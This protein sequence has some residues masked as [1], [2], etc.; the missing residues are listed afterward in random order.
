MAT[1][2]STKTRQTTVKKEAPGTKSKRLRSKLGMLMSVADVHDA[3]AYPKTV[4]AVMQQMYLGIIP[5]A[6]ADRLITRLKQ[7]CLEC[8]GTPYEQAASLKQDPLLNLRPLFER[9]H[10][11][12]MSLAQSVQDL[13]D[14]R[15]RLDEKKKWLR[16]ITGILQMQKEARLDA[17][18]YWL[19]VGKDDNPSRAGQRVIYADCHVLMFAV[20]ND[21][22]HPHSLIEAPVGHGKS[23]NLRGQIS[24]EI[25]RWPELRHLYLTESKPL[26]V[27]TIRSLRKI[28]TS[29]R[30]KVLFPAVNILD[31]N[32]KAE[33]SSQSFTVGRLNDQARDPTIMG[34]GYKGS[35]QG[36]RY[37]RIW[38]DDVCP[39]DVKKQ[40]VVREDN[41]RV[42]THV[43]RTRLAD[44]KNSKIR[45]I[46][47]P[48]HEDDILG[49]T[50]RDWR[51]GIMPKWR[52]EIDRFRIKIDAT[53]MPIPIWPALWDAE[54]LLAEK[55]TNSAFRFTH[56]LRFDGASTR[57]LSNVYFYNSVPRTGVD[58]ESDFALN[59]RICQGERWLSIDPAGTGNAWSSGQGLVEFV[60][61]P[62]GYAFLTNVWFLQED[63][64]TFVNR[65][66]DII[67]D[68]SV[69]GN[70]RYR[71]TQ[72]EVQ[73]G[74]KI[75][76]PGLEYMFKQL[77]A[78]RGVTDLQ[79]VKTG[80]NVGGAKRSQS[81]RQR[82]E[83]A[84]PYLGSGMVRLAGQRNGPQG[85]GAIP[86]SRME[87]LARV[88]KTWD[89]EMRDSDAIDATSQ[90]ILNFKNRIKDP[91]ENIPQAPIPTT[92]A[93]TVMQRQFLA[94][95]DAVI[96][97]DPDSD[98]QKFLA[99][100]GRQLAGVA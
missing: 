63:I 15:I 82:F 3:A 13:S 41:N 5:G 1:A 69:P 29:P 34:Q 39:P 12:L 25:G 11:D 89:G 18:K 55:K 40:A 72:W 4:R 86:N 62:K 100:M 83:N 59:D 8:T 6:D 57:I 75:A 30:F 43:I 93:T 98:E 68:P 10:D 91:A 16:T 31:R 47:T 52:V 38:G 71:G 49:R 36:S 88:L 46:G 96:E 87:K 61:G 99:Q 9:G 78:K 53:G 74:T 48:W 19:Y 26:A 85:M 54:T 76:F 81:K 84:A 20:W 66:V 51:K 65:L 50:L 94:S 92:K 14:A 73:S 70:T 79:M 27:R 28:I 42:W 35:I 97:T 90:W 24:Y 58:P 44:P 56:E 95:L 33:D 64:T 23:T 7:Q 80:A 67:V 17:A 60:I 37:D 77:L 2:E 32:Q 45:L 22:D 21:P